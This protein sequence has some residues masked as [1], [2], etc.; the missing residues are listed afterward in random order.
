MFLENKKAVLFPTTR[1][2]Y[3]GIKEISHTLKPHNIHRTHSNLFN[4]Y[5]FPNLLGISKTFMSSAL[6][7][8]LI[9]YIPM[10]L[11]TM[12]SPCRRF[13]FGVITRAEF[14]QALYSIKEFCTIVFQSC[15]GTKIYEWLRK[16][17]MNYY[18]MRKFYLK[19]G[20]LRFKYFYFLC[21]R[22]VTQLEH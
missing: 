7:L 2:R 6:A 17:I 11:L 5:S 19:G 20:K 13:N 8:I 21:Q 18:I 22:V 4:I 9:T 12:W 10:H 15:G 14:E 16:Y 3:S 1:R